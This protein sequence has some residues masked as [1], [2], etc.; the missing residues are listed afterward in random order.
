MG[1]THY[2]DTNE[3]I[4]NHPNYAIAIKAMDDL[5]ENVKQMSVQLC[6]YNLVQPLECPAFVQKPETKIGL[7]VRIWRFFFAR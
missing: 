7:F 1:Y 2:W 3:N 6:L 4:K 5:V